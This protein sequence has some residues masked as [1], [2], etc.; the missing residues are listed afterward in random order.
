MTEEIRAPFN[1]SSNETHCFRLIMVSSA[2]YFNDGDDDND[3][4]KEEDRYLGLFEQV[5]IFTGK[6][7]G[8]QASTGKM[9]AIMKSR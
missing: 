9:V 8:R 4:R 2:E 1:V 3:D 6:I 7:P 5:W